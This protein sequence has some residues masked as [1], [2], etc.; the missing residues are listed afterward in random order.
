MIKIEFIKNRFVY[1]NWDLSFEKQDRD[2]WWKVNRV[3]ISK[4]C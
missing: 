3:Y 4:S 1:L 2:F